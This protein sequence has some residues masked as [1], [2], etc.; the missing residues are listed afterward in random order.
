MK[1]LKLLYGLLAYLLFLITILY[2]IGFVGNLIVPKSIDSGRTVSLTQALL[3]DAALL[4][5]FALQHSGM[6]RPAF[7]R[8][9]GRRLPTSI[10]RS[11][12]VLASSAAL[13][14]LFAAWQPLGGV[15]WDL[16]HPMARTGLTVLYFTGWA[17]VFASTFYINHFD[18]F[19]LRQSL[20]A[21]RGRPY[22]P[23][24]FVTP[25]P[26]RYTRHPLYLGFLIAFW[27]APTMT[28]SHLLFSIATTGYILVAIQLEER[29]LVAAHPEYADYRRS[30]P[31]LIPRPT[32]SWPAPAGDRQDRGR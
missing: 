29:D 23:V 28:W 6:A 16:S 30:V 11:T 26:Y 13:L 1:T 17:L 25:L 5:L 27:S 4:L 3:V 32:F 31:M 10:E 2:A 7:K 24:H 20:L 9:L 19:G 18:L 21:F 14:L 8:W 12:Y 15:V 22:T